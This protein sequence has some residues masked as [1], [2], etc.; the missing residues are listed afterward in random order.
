MRI[1]VYTYSYELNKPR[2]PT[3]RIVVF[4][5]GTT[6]WMVKGVAKEQNASVLQTGEWT[7]RGGEVKTVRTHDRCF[8]LVRVGPVGV[9]IVELV[10]A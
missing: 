5:P 3:V 4:R 10:R 6:G 9:C 1:V 7:G 2:H 8:F